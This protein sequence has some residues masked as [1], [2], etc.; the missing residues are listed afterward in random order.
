MS[1]PK[2][3]DNCTLT[4]DRKNNVKDIV[5]CPLHRDAPDLLAA[6]KEIRFTAAAWCCEDDSGSGWSS[7]RSIEDMAVDAILKTKLPT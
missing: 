2:T 5:L 1:A 4:W 7:L 3:C 6:L